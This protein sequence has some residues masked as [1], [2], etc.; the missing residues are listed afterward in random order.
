MCRPR[1]AAT[2]FVGLLTCAFAAACGGT[3]EDSEA[4]RPNVIL[5]SLDTLRQ[6]RCG[7]HGYGRDT[8]PFL[9][10]LASESLVFENARATAP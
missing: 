9:D 10:E 4:G 7:F 5:I 1:R 8:T 3:G 6:D 2:R